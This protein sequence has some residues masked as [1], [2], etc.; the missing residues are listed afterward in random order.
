MGIEVRSINSCDRTILD[1]LYENYLKELHPARS[2]FPTEW[3][4]NIYTQALAGQRCLWLAF[5]EDNAIGF[6]DFKIMPSF[7]G[8]SQKYAMVFDFY[9]IPPQRRCGYGTQLARFVLDEICQQN[10]SSVELNV[11]P[12]NKKAMD[13]WQSLGF[14]LRH[15]TLEMLVS[16]AK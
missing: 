7:P 2:Q 8:S 13:F 10:A 16:E 11:L 1:Q 9:I 14:N 3:I 6:V 15:Y 4:S 12:N 5:V